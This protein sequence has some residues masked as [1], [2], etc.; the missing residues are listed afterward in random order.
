MRGAVCRCLFR[1]P[2]ACF[3]RESISATLDEVFAAFPAA[4][5]KRQALNAAVEF[6]VAAIKRLGLADQIALDG[7]YISAKANPSDVDM[8]VLTPG[9]YQMAGKGASRP[10]A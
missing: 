3:H 9:V 2:M 1:V 4:T 10:K 8:V 5:T 7:S 6:C